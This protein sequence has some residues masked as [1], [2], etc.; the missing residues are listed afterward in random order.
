LFPSSQT[1]AAV[2][3]YSRSGRLVTLANV[4]AE[5][6]RQVRHANKRAPPRGA[7]HPD[8]YRSFLFSVK[9]LF[10]L[11]PSRE[12]HHACPPHF[13]TR[14]Q[15]E[16]ADVTVY[17]V[18]DPIVG[19]D[20]NA[21]D[22]GVLESPV[23]TP[24][25]V[26]QADC[27]VFGAPGRQGGVCCEMSFFLDSLRDFQTNG[28]LLKGKVGS[29]FTSVGGVGCGHGGH[30]GVLQSFHSFFLQ[31]GMLSV[32]VPPSPMMEMAPLATPLGTCMNG[33]ESGKDTPGSRLRA[34]SE[35]E[36]KLAYSQGEWASII[37]KQLHDDGD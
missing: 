10:L 28:C 14:N 8:D 12:T 27:I 21:F 26:L 9:T 6:I 30:E 25:V 1:Q 33:K 5:G 2:I 3:Y 35:E 37:T 15:V 7:S 13:F 18:K 17:R 4:I 24:E 31:H 22:R 29:A 23:A 36:V 11:L 32:G 20:Y 34:L 19:D 16:G